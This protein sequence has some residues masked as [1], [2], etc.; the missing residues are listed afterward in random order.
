MADESETFEKQ[1][2]K[3]YEGTGNDFVQSEA[4]DKADK[5]RRYEDR[6]I[7]IKRIE[8]RASYISLCRYSL[9]SK[10]LLLTA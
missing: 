2:K 7:G 3:L 8:D 5:E 1:L 9:I 10:L 4:G 6:I